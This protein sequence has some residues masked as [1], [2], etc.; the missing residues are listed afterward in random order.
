M[1]KQ[2]QSTRNCQSNEAAAARP[3]REQILDAALALFAESGSRGTSVAAVAERVGITDAG[4]LYH[5][6]TKEELLLGV[7]AHFDR[8]VEETLADSGARGVQLLRLVRDWGAGMERVP[9][10][11]SL[12]ILLSAEHLTADSP[13][14]RTIQNRYR[15]LLD[16]YTA[17]FAAAAV[18]GD[19]R[20]DLNPVHEASALVAHLDGIRLQWFL[21][22]RSFSMADSVRT[23]VDTAL[24]RLAPS[25]DG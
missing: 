2:P 3:R 16:R 7:L 12:L 1:G 4:V 15:R 9:E 17:A 8:S 5:F 14:R 13:A 18:T 6:R 19:L 24:A 21:L 22:D 20:H 11:S 25:A 10:V 23:Y